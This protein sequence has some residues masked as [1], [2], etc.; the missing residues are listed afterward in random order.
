MKTVLAAVDFSQVSERVMATAME[1]AQKSPARIVVL[2]VV[3]APIVTSEYAPLIDHVGEIIAA[4]EKAA[5]QR[6]RKVARELRVRGM[7]CVTVQL[8]G[9]PVASIL[10]Q[11]Q[12]HE[13]DYIVM[14]S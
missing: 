10:A 8:T 12:R 14:G 13:A 2:S 6:L 7:D 9:S 4:G 1:L 3:Q 5:E 11:A